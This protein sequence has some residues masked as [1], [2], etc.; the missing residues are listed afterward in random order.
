MSVPGSDQVGSCG[1]AEAWTILKEDPS[2]V[3]IDVRS[4]PEWSFVGVPDLSSLGK[5]VV[6]TEWRVFP[7]MQVN[8]A[9]LDSVLAG[10]PELPTKMLFIC[11]SGARSLDAARCVVQA[12]ADRG[13]QADCINVEEGF[14]GDLDAERH[15]AAV[16]GWKNAGLPWQQS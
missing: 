16:N 2:A 4:R 13:Q 10:L 15:R 7:N 3:L 1:P 12:L 11:R 8:E 9:F 5:A 14:E 6:L